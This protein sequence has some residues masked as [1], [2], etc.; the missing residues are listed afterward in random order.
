LE[1]DSLYKEFVSAN[2]FKNFALKGI[3]QDIQAILKKIFIRAHD[4]SELMYGAHLSY[5]CLLQNAKFNSTHF[6]DEWIEW[7]NNI[8][9]NM[10]DFKG[11]SPTDLFDLARTAKS[12]TRQFIFDW[13]Q[14]VN[15]D[16]MDI[17]RRNELV[18]N[19]EFHNKRGK[20]RLRLKKHDDIKEDKWIGLK[21][22]DYRFFNARVILRDIVT[23]LENEH[24][25]F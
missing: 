3:E 1:N 21:Y 19:L 11:F 20:A 16:R 15:T 17:N 13:W 4:F 9:K 18:E 24:N 23:I 6:E 2:S 8:E 12:Y 5:N 22:L 10:I 25:H 7:S 14:F